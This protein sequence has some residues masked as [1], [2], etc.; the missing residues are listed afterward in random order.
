MI[1]LVG[2]FQ[3]IFIIIFQLLAELKLRFFNYREAKIAG[4]PGQVKKYNN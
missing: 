3:P 2:R 4:E 1:N